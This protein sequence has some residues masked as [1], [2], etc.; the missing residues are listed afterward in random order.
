MELIQFFQQLH[1]LEEVLVGVIQEIQVL[2]V[3]L[4]VVELDII[5]QL[6]E[7]VETLRLYLHLKVIM[8]EVHLVQVSLKLEVVE[9]VLEVLVL[10]VLVQAQ[11]LLLV[12]LEQLLI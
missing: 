10:I 7:E 11:L 1:L 3:D 8:V 9:E 6:L 5:R 12:E 4:V 2:M